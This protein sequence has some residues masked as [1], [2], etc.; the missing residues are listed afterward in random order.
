MQ[1][2]TGLPEY[3]LDNLNYTD[4]LHA[5]YEAEY[6]ERLKMDPSDWR[7]IACCADGDMWV[8]CL[9]LIFGGA[10]FHDRQLQPEREKLFSRGETAINVCNSLRGITQKRLDRFSDED[11]HEVWGMFL[12][13]IDAT[14]AIQDF[15]RVNHYF[16]QCPADLKA[17]FS[18][19]TGQSPNYGQSRYASMMLVEHFLK[20]FIMLVAGNK[21][22]H[23]HDIRKLHDALKASVPDLDFSHLFDDLHC[24]AAVRYGE[25]QTT[26]K[27]A[28]AAHKACL[29]AVRYLGSIKRQHIV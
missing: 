27:E 25:V 16:A 7:C 23:G 15:V 26:R 10:I 22:P 13:G 8:I 5:W 19:L 3:A 18:G 9:P 21:P 17:S 24:T 29:L 1:N 12:V 28:Y 2:N 6:G 20:G 11:L 14:K 4:A